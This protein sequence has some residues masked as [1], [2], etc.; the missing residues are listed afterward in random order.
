MLAKS[1]KGKSL[2]E[3]QIAL[4][5]SLADGYKP[6]LALVFMSINHDINALCNLLNELG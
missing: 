2:S 4:A 6:T 3:I 5:D 1:I